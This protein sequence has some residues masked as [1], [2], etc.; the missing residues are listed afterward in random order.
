MKRRFFISVFGILAFI[1]SNISYAQTMRFYSTENKLSNSLINK[2]YQDCN[3]FIWVATEWGLN[4]YDSYKFIVYNHIEGDSS[5]IRDNYIHTLFEDSNN[6]LYIATV[7]GAM[8]YNSGAETFEDI[9][10][11]DG[12][13]QQ[14]PHITAFVELLD[15]DIWMGTSE[16]GVF[17]LKK[18]ED[19]ANR[20]SDL[21]PHSEII[22]FTA[23]YRDKNDNIWLGT[24][25]K[26]LLFYDNRTRTITTYNTQHGL[27]NNHISS[28]IEDKDGHLFVGTLTNGLN[29][30]HKES[31]SFEPIPCVGKEDL[32]V[33]SLFITH[34]NELLIGT[35]GQG[36]KTYDNKQQI[37]KD[38]AVDAYSPYLSRGK[39]HSI[40]QDRDGNLWFG[41]FQKGILFIPS[42]KNNFGYW[43]SNTYNEN[44]LGSS[45]IMSVY[46]DNEDVA[47]IG[48]DNEGIF[49]VDK[50]GKRIAHFS[51]LTNSNI[52]NVILAIFEDNNE[53]LWL[54]SYTKGL[55]K[56]N[57]R[58]GECQIIPQ[59]ENDRVFSINQDQEGRLIIATY[60]SGFYIMEKN[61]EFKQ[62][63]A[64]IKSQNN[65]SV[66][67]LSG[68][69]INMILCD[70]EGLLWFGH[71]KGLTCYDPEKNTFLPFLNSNN[72]LPET[73][74]V[75]LREDHLGRIWIGTIKGL[76]CFDKETQSMKH[77]TTEDGLPNNMIC[78]IEED[79]NGYIWISTFY[80]VSKY[81]PTE[82][83]FTN[84]YVGNG[85]QGNEFTR[86][87]SFKD[88]SGNIFFGGTHGITFFDPTKISLMKNELNIAMTGLFVGDRQTKQGDKSGSNVIMN[89]SLSDLSQ[90]TL[91]HSDNS[92]SLEFSSLEYS[93]ADH[94]AY[95]Y[96]LDRLNSSWQSTLTGVNTITYNHL[97][98]G[99][100]KLSVRAIGNNTVSQIKTIKIQI[101]PPWYRTWWAHTLSFIFVVLA[102]SGV[103]K[104]FISQF[105][106]KQEIMKKEHNEA[107]NE[108]KLQFFINI[109]HEIRTP[110]TLI[111]NPLKKLMEE[112][113]EMARQNT[114]LIIQRNAQ[115]ILRLI[116]QLMDIRKLDK[117]LM[118]IKCR[119]TDIVGF[120]EDLMLTFE[121]LAKKKNVSFNFTHKDESMKVWID[122]N[123]FDK[124]LMNVLSNAFKFIPDGGSIDIELT[125]IEIDNARHF[126][127][128][129]SDTGIG[130][131][132]SH[133][134]DIFKRFYQIE[135]SNSSQYEGTGVGLHLSRLLV[136]L[137]HGT[138]HAENRKDTTGCHFIIRLPLGK[139]HLK[140]EELETSSNPVSLPEAEDVKSYVD[141]LNV[142]KTPTGGAKGR[143]AKTK[144]NI[145]LIE[146]DD[147]IRN[148]MLGEL[149]GDYRV[150]GCK[151][152]KEGYDAIILQQ[153]D[154]VISDIMMPE[155]DGITLCRKIK[156][157]INV[158]HIPII[159]LTAKTRIE[160]K[161]EGLE[162]GADAYLSKPFNTSELKQNINN[163]IENRVR[164][165][166][167]YSG[168]QEQQDKIV[169]LKMRS[170]DEILMDK[171]M[172]VINTNL[173]NPGLNVEMLA[174]SI[175][176]S[177]VHM[178][179][180][181]KDLTNQSAR[182][183]I[184]GIRLKQAAN[185]LSDKKLSVSEIAYAT[186]F[187]NLSHF[188][189][190]FR[191]FY[192]ISPKSYMGEQTDE[193][194]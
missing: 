38:Y 172:H 194:V 125:T 23:I 91:T 133:I 80:G 152:G 126:Q 106:Y 143:K 73:R 155:M 122:L 188:S 84:F 145:I 192:G 193:E 55:A 57:K 120:I 93:T 191:A 138:I 82:N 65:L 117:C 21:F 109:S 186:G 67:L 173:S 187:T 127:I 28:I 189:S 142:E 11:Y 64:N 62:H 112:D 22:S 86:G 48:T 111:I 123:N 107:I 92:F 41:L 161:I 87:A 157:N 5:S 183:F 119:E 19:K 95:Q 47:W 7:S 116:N 185:L 36:L 163:L 53:T 164:L 32:F 59:F 63:L 177:R 18:G 128:K 124:V 81:S 39:V 131:E 105:R 102:I 60:G 61:G 156:Q 35:D 179:R 100:Y 20:L 12:G 31:N 118:H 96:K 160:D 136:E 75:S 16:Q 150:K 115:R 1:S 147:E 15:G 49:S 89:S 51:P 129:V 101:L 74:V 132:D 134:E 66:D 162:I 40:L 104:Y 90:I 71:H 180:K 137:H 181:L 37:I 83:T 54:G 30:F 3:N 154:L 24:E 130:I 153:P 135:S 9:K 2:I 103:I 45:C 50:N 148:Y 33:K 85:L 56:M 175:G 182:D 76:Y 113:L 13:K 79:Q 139:A 46:K 149:S 190:T 184:K 27:S 14:F 8:R 68:N 169:K 178:H 108:A 144:Y 58:T 72:I 78:G 25:N 34:S 10:L 171:I 98:P 26:G 114:Y 166:A 17:C 151:N 70:K 170:S 4:K 44:P 88:K 110:M 52:P 42:V 99:S 146:D 167:K 140:P 121:D 141:I 174:N 168:K 29:R 94:I 158:N 159:L 176:M 43:G 97:P 77:L 165:K 69:W 6:T